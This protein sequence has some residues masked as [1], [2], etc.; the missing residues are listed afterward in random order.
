MGS[1]PTLMPP[2]PPLVPLPPVQG[3]R[4]PSPVL[5][6]TQPVRLLTGY[7]AVAGRRGLPSST[8]DL[9]MSP[10]LPQHR[11]LSL[12]LPTPSWT[13]GVEG[14]PLPTPELLETLLARLPTRLP[15]V[16]GRGGR[17]SLP[18]LVRHTQAKPTPVRHMLVQLIQDKPILVR[19]SVEPLIQGQHI[20][21]LMLLLNEKYSH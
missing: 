14:L 6:G 15:G 8:L 13:P 7:Q 11:L 5:L 10:H 20:R 3:S 1:L 17:L 21:K 16:A 12:T 4:E 9:L 18:T 2:P 19:P